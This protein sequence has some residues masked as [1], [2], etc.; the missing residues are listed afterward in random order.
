MITWIL[1]LPLLGTEITLANAS[2]KKILIIFL[3]CTAL[4]AAGAFIAYQIYFYYL[5]SEFDNRLAPQIQK[6]KDSITQKNIQETIAALERVKDRY[7]SLRVGKTADAGVFLNHQLPLEWYVAP[8]N[9]EKLQAWQK[10]WPKIGEE[11]ITATQDIIFEK[12]LDE[13]DFKNIP[14]APDSGLVNFNELDVTWFDQIQNYDHWNLEENSPLAWKTDEA[15]GQMGWVLNLIDF[16]QYVDVTHLKQFFLHRNAGT[17]EEFSTKSMKLAALLIS[18]EDNIM[19]VKADSIVKRTTEL[20]ILEGA[21]IQTGLFPGD[22]NLSTISRNIDNLMHPDAALSP[23]TELL[24]AVKHPLVC[25]GLHDWFREAEIISSYVE[26]D[27]AYKKRVDDL[28]ESHK[29]DCRFHRIRNYRGKL[30]AQEPRKAISMLPLRPKLVNPRFTFVD[31]QP[32]IAKFMYSLMV[33]P[34][35]SIPNEK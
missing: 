27:A 15:Y 12:P 19:T 35:Q 2:I 7:P 6:Y 16:F 8:E 22:P 11:T 13:A 25:V 31:L 1:F 34:I 24:L 33:T 18:S 28:F 21:T 4:I 29:D 5:I 30:A 10:S 26:Q 17:L 9:K 3:R 23:L 32:T 20:L 14:P